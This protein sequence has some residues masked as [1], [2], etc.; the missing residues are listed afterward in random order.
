MNHPHEDRLLLLAYGELPDADAAELETHL[1]ACAA[2]R[3]DL[4]RLERT[5]VALEWAVPTQRRRARWIAAGL[6]AAALLAAVFLTRRGSPQQEVWQ[7]LH[8]WSPTAGYMAG[9]P[10][11]VEIDAQ[12]TRLERERFY[13]WPN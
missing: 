7:P 12:L 11:V 4:A 13:G 6:A 9:G 1:A 5:W 8:V 3:E 10:S 2:C